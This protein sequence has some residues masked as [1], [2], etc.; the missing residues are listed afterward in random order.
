MTGLAPALAPAPASPAG[1]DRAAERARVVLLV[2]LAG[3]GALYLGFGLYY[4]ALIATPPLLNRSGTAAG[5]DFVA[6]WAATTLAAGG[7]AVAAYD[8]ARFSSLIASVAPVLDRPNPWSYPPVVM[9]MLRP[10]G[11]VD[12]MPALLLWY[13][14]ISGAA[15]AAVRVATGRWTASGWALLFPPVVHSLI[16]GQNGTITALLLGAVVA[17]FRRAPFAAGLAL[18]LLAYKPHLAVVPA[19]LAL[20][21]GAW[22]VLAGAALTAAVLVAGS[23]ALDGAAPWAGFLAQSQAQLALMTSGRIPIHRLITPFALL[24][25]AGMP[26]TLALALHGVAALA[27]IAAAIHVWRRDENLLPRALSLM[28]A[29]VLVTPYAYDYD[30]AILVV[31]A[32]GAA[33]A[34][35]TPFALDDAAMRW[36]VVLALAPVMTLVLAAG[37][38]IPFGTIAI[39]AALAIVALRPRWVPSAPA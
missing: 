35:P 21:F 27:A 24:Y 12:A 38:K 4:G 20:A 32:A 28:L 5:G 23:L 11:W 37:S 9:L 29:A 22:R 33:A 14:L 7:D 6:F 34:P 39:V 13:A 25:A 19:C 31:P 36:L 8:P 18:G 10:L 30:L 26:A 3:I 1:G 15:F 16:N 2:V 17:C